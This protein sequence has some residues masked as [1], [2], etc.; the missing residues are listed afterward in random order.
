MTSGKVIINDNLGK[1]RI[2]PRRFGSDLGCGEIGG[3][4][5]TSMHTHRHGLGNLPSDAHFMGQLNQYLASRAC[6]SQC[7]G[8]EFDPH[9]LH[10]FNQL[11]VRDCDA[12]VRSSCGDFCGEFPER[13]TTRNTGSRVFT[14]RSAA[15][16]KRSM[17]GADGPTGQVSTLPGFANEG[18]VFREEIA[19]LCVHRGRSEPRL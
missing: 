10:Q 5:C 13:P 8:R 18:A 12:K 4:W 9:R 1:G 11:L 14:T 15:S 17:D 2:A 3:L 7:G 19:C 6:S 16:S